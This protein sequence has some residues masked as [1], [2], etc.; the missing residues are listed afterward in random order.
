MPFFHTKSQTVKK[1]PFF[2]CQFFAEKILISE[3]WGGGDGGIAVKA[4]RGVLLPPRVQGY[5]DGVLSRL[6]SAKGG[7]KTAISVSSCRRHKI[8]VTLHGAA[9]VQG[10][11]RYLQTSV[12]E[13]RNL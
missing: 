11:K 12:P 9:L 13:A 3:F 7:R 5:G 10:T 1:V 6:Y 2:F 8:P 4:V